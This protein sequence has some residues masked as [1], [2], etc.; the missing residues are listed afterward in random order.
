MKYFRFVKETDGRWFIELP[1][2]KGDKSDLEM[3]FG[4]DT[5]LDIAAQG[6]MVSYLTISEEEYD[7]HRFTLNL[8]GEEDGGGR[9]NLKSEMYEFDVWLCH[10]TK[11][12]FGGRLPTKLYVSY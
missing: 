7:D 6:E 9:Y 10:V 11:F 5:M 8:I 12:V 2:W 4:A 3:V 1:E